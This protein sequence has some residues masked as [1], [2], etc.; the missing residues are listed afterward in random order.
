[1][2]NMKANET[3]SRQDPGH[4]SAE[5]SETRRAFP[6]DTDRASRDLIDLNSEEGVIV[7]GQVAGYMSRKEAA[8]RPSEVQAIENASRDSNFQSNEALG[9]DQVQGKVEWLNGMDSGRSRE[10]LDL[11]SFEAVK[12]RPA[13][14]GNSKDSYYDGKTRLY[15]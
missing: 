9:R 13:A 12:A 3:A 4:G 14:G 8:I 1:M 7:D 5:Q 15:T 11:D 2:D 10:L 6:V